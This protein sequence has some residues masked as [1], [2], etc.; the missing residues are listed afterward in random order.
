MRQACRHTNDSGADGLWQVA[1]LPAGLR[2]GRRCGRSRIDSGGGSQIRPPVGGAGIESWRRHSTESVVECLQNEPRSVFP[3]RFA[4]RQARPSDSAHAAYRGGPW[5]R[6]REIHSS[7]FRRMYYRSRPGSLYRAPG[8]ILPRDGIDFESEDSGGA[9]MSLF[10]KLRWLAR[11]QAKEAELREELQFHLEEEAEEREGLPKKEALWAARRELGNL[12]IV[13]ESTRAAW[14]WTT[15]EQL[16]QDLRSGVRSMLHNRAF[17]ALATLSLALGI[18]ANTAIYSFMDS[19]LL[20]AL[21]VPDPPSLAVLN[22]H[23]KAPRGPKP[24]HVMHG[25]DGSTWS[26]GTGETGGIFPFGAFELLRENRHIFSSLFAY[27]GSDKH[28]LTIKGQAEIA[29]GEYV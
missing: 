1:G 7:D 24:N 14:G 15:L 13:Q 29:G 9:V 20:R 2:R 8:G 11:R 12:T 17:T 27:Y 22:W 10:R 23:S 26:D 6:H 4:A 16:G 19:L 5:P 28:N 3:R 21:P 25:M 18:G